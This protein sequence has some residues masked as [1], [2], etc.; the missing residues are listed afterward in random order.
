MN[1]ESVGLQNRCCGVPVEI[2]PVETNSGP[3]EGIQQ[4]CE[5]F[6]TAIILLCCI[7]G[8]MLLAAGIALIVI[9]HCITGGVLIGLSVALI[10]AATTLSGG[11]RMQERKVAEQ[12]A[13]A[14]D[15]KN[16]WYRIL[17]ELQQE[18]ERLVTEGLT[19]GE[20]EAS[21]YNLAADLEQQWCKK[22]RR[23][24][25]RPAAIEAGE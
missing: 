9:T 5:K 7:V 10:V 24:L 23:I 11:T 15:P 25:E 3:L 14:T 18:N 4:C 2:R 21:A 17:E 1:N 8:G 20:E 12:V 22:W 16:K 13:R 19:A 6:P